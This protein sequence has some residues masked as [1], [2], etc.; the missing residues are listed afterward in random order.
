MSV[1]S[2]TQSG[3]PLAQQALAKGEG[4][5]KAPDHDEDADDAGVKAAKQV[6]PTVNISGQAIETTI[7]TKA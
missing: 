5:E 6:A 4:A 3:A 7:S 1:S 2:V